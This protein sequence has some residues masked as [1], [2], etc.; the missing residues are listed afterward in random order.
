MRQ[1]WGA[2]SCSQYHS[3]S[4]SE[5]DTPALRSRILPIYNASALGPNLAPQAQDSRIDIEGL[6]NIWQEEFTWKTLWLRIY[7]LRSNHDGYY[8]IIRMPKLKF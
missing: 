3:S 1:R 6:G 8:I 2:E 4:A 5:M 7:I